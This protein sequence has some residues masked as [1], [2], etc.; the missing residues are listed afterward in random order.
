[1]NC[2]HKTTQISRY[3]FTVY[4]RFQ[5]RTYHEVWEIVTPD[6]NKLAPSGRFFLFAY[7]ENDF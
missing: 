2:G 5:M 6:H 4:S 7:I 1:M 3:L